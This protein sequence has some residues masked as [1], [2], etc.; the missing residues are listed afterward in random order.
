MEIGT[1]Q[2][3]KAERKSI[4]THLIGIRSPEETITAGEY[5]RLVKHCVT[6]I[7]ERGMKPI[8]CGGSGLYYR[9]ITKGI[10]D[11]SKSDTEI[12][13]SAI[14][15]FGLRT[16]LDIINGMFAFAFYDNK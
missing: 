7:Q 14:D 8:I 2:H 6:D 3:T 16:T 11:G 12:L 10:F 15:H 13:L 4:P 5:A 9:A 1:A